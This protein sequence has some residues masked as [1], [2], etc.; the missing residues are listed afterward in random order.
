MGTVPGDYAPRLPMQALRQPEGAPALGEI[1]QHKGDHTG[2][3]RCPQAAAG[4]C[5]KPAGAQQVAAEVGQHH[6]AHP[7]HTA[8]GLLTD[9]CQQPGHDGIG[10]QITPS[11]AK[12]H[13][14]AGCKP[15]KH[16]QPGKAQQQIAAG[17]QHRQRRR[18]QGPS[19]KNGK[20]PQRQADRPDGN[21]RLAPAGR[22][23]QCRVQPV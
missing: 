17:G 7:G 10:Q 18:Q 20:D 16:R 8:A 13:P 6:P 1:G 14:G 11:D 22:H 21:A 5:H 3:E 4:G 23:R 9:H 15:C 12:Q 19:Q 2:R